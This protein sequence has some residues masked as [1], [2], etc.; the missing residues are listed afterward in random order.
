MRGELTENWHDKAD[1]QAS[2]NTVIYSQRQKNCNFWQN[3]EAK[4]SNQSK[5]IIFAKHEFTVNKKK[6]KENLKSGIKFNITIKWTHEQ[7]KVMNFKDSLKTEF[8]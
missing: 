4:L 7:V 8:H 5:G 3:P 2:L 6:R 1:N